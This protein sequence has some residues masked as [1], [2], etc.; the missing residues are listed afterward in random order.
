[1]ALTFTDVIADGDMDQ[2]LAFRVATVVLDNSY[3]TGGEVIAETDLQL[4]VGS[5][6]Y[7]AVH[8]V[9]PADTNALVFSFDYT[10]KK[11]M[12][13]RTDQVDDFLEQVPNTTDLSTVTLRIFAIGT[14]LH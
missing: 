8:Q 1:M 4:A 3:P 2:G 5:L 11:I 12:A 13:F 7:V 9:A 14:P 10:N 6:K